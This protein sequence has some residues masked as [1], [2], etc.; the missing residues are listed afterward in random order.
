MHYSRRPVWDRARRGCRWST[1]H[2][3]RAGCHHH[4]LVRL[5]LVVG[6]HVNMAAPT[7]LQLFVKGLS[8]PFGSYPVPL[9][10]LLLFF[11]T[12]CLPQAVMSAEL[13]LL[14]SSKNGGSIL[15]VERAM[16]STTRCPPFTGALF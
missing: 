15:W 7:A 10:M 3:H 9:L 4:L 2:V 5:F 13:A 8:F 16:V 6:V 12:R 14:C 11:C 1:L